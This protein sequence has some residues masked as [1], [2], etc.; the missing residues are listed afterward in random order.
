MDL[1][2]YGGR[3]HTVDRH[4]RTVR[5]IAVR[6]DRIAAVGDDAD[7][8]ALGTPRTRRVNLGGATMVPG[9][10]DSHVHFG[11]EL[12]KFGRADL[13]DSD[14]VAEVI[15]RLKVHAGT[16]A[17]GEWVLAS[18]F[19]HE[20]LTRERRLPSLAELDEAFSDRVAV[21]PR[22]CRRMMVNSVALRLAGIDGSTPDPE[23]GTIHRDERSQPTGLV[24]GAAQE[25]V[26]RHKPPLTTGE[27]VSA[28]RAAMRRYNELGLT[29]IREASASPDDA[30]I[31]QA[32]HADHAMTLRVTLL[33]MGDPLGNV[34]GPVSEQG[35]LQQLELNIARTGFGDEWLRVGGLKMLID[36][37]LEGAWMREPYANAPESRGFIR[38]S[39][40]MLDRFLSTLVRLDWSLAMHVSGDAAMDEFLAAMERLAGHHDVTGLRWSIEHTFFCTPNQC[41]QMKRLGLT[42]AVHMALMYDFGD[43]M[44]LNWGRERASRLMPVRDMVAAGLR[45]A[46]GSD[47][48]FVNLSPLMGMQILMTRE[49]A[50]AGPF[51]PD[52]AVDARTA[53]EI[54]T[55]NNAWLTFDDRIRGTLEPGK[56]ADLVVLGKDPLS[57]PPEEVGGIPV[58]MTMAGGRAVYE[59]GI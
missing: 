35:V 36:G 11:M 59:N 57:C 21:V 28:M 25:L 5:A 15:R 44:V 27:K 22:G 10:M 47:G 34:E 19:W 56:L 53:L 50:V 3:V 4:S 55:R 46:G 16:L 20:S 48:P 1:I 40:S 13:R 58:L 42:P 31:L 54:Y 12:D 26:M 39:P 23:S 51:D 43:A 49:T 45:P 17:R 18:P 30:H 8:L 24:T 7:I 33:P 32:L 14:S 52:Q 9:L 37:S 6:G 38:M 29:G 41:A 2:L